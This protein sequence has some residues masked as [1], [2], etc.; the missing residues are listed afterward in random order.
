MN[1]R[2]LSFVSVLLVIGLAGFTFLRP[3]DAPLSVSSS[4]PAAP[5]SE[6]LSNWSVDKAHSE[7]RFSVRHLAI[8]SVTGFFRD[9]DAVVEMAPNDL[10]S[11]KASATIRTGSID[12]GNDK[13]DEHLRSPDFFDAGTFPEMTFESTGVSNVDGKTF[14][15]NGTLT[16]RDVSKPVTLDGELVGTAIGPRGNERAALTASTVINRKAFG[17][18][19]N[20]LTE[21]GGVIVGEDVTITIDVQVMRPRQG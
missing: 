19:W 11:L 6:A 1:R 21:A 17:L 15:L 2:L 20:K 10:N 16:I 18:T 14:A 13:R 12:T 4:S 5:V 8:S 9:Y 3:A 7:V